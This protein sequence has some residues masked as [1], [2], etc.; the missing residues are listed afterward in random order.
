MKNVRAML[1]GR[2]P[3]SARPRSLQLGNAAVRLVCGEVATIAGLEESWQCVWN[4]REKAHAG[5]GRSRLHDLHSVEGCF[6]VADVLD[7][8]ELGRL[9]R[10]RVAKLNANAPVGVTGARWC[11]VNDE[12]TVVLAFVC[13]PV[14][15]TTASGGQ[16]GSD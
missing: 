3:L 12:P 4:V 13:V 11:D 14:G 5:C 1:W 16:D 10:R 7:Q 15:T 9:L 2:V 6:A 8:K